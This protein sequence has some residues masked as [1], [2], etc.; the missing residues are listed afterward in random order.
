MRLERV[1]M[2]LDYANTLGT[3]SPSRIDTIRGYAPYFE[4][5]SLKLGSSEARIDAMRFFLGETSLSQSG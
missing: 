3:A 4:K 1:L 5:H 2:Y